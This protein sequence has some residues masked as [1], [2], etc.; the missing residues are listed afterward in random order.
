MPV[1]SSHVFTMGEGFSGSRVKLD[2]GPA[3][4]TQ[5]AHTESAA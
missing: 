3:D 2:F 4:N 5:I 1:L